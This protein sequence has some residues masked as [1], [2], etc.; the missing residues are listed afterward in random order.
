[1]RGVRFVTSIPLDLS[2]AGKYGATWPLIPGPFT[3]WPIDPLYL[4]RLV[5]TEP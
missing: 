5:F 4:R 1:M 3:A 2:P